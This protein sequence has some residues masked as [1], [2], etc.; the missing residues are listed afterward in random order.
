MEQLSLW[1]SWKQNK[2]QNTSSTEVRAKDWEKGP[3][4]EFHKIKS[5]V[6]FVYLQQD[7][8]SIAAIAH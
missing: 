7:N 2:V 6:L 3:E 5:S 1:I 4:S 8:D